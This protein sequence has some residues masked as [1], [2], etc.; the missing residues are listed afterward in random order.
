MCC[1][2]R[3]STP[4]QQVLVSTLENIAKE[5]KGM[6]TPAIIVVGEVVKLREKLKW[7]K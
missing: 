3:G 7:F 5:S 6:P 4:E 2:S 1:N